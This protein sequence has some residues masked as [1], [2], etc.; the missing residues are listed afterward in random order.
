MSQIL[1]V[2]LVYKGTA[3]WLLLGLLRH[4]TR[5]YGDIIYRNFLGGSVECAATVEDHLFEQKSL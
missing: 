2:S 3:A 5:R 1:P 4:V